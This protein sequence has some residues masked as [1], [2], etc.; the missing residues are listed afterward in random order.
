[1]N[2][3]RWDYIISGKEG[4]LARIIVMLIPAG[5]FT[6]LT[7]D[8]LQPQPGKLRM[9]ALAFAGMAIPMLG[10]TIYLLNRYFFFKVCIGEDGFYYQSSPF[11]GKYYRYAD[12]VSCREEHQAYR[13]KHR[14][15]TMHY[16][17]FHF[18]TAEGRSV[19]FLFEKELHAREISTLKERIE[20]SGAEHRAAMR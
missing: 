8:Q 1:M 16:Y 13:P 18:D 6:M 19:R 3:E 17:Y 7:I 14:T 2:N 9:L 11:G 4:G 10:I 5:L 20:A 12:V 15:Q